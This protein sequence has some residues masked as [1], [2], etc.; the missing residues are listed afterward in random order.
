MHDISSYRRMP[1]LK[2]YADNIVKWIQ[3]PPR[4]QF[5]DWRWG[6]RSR[7]RRNKDLGKMQEYGEPSLKKSSLQSKPGQNVFEGRNCLGL[8]FGWT[9]VESLDI[10]YIEPSLEKRTKIERK[11][12]QA[13]MMCLLVFV[14]GRYI[15]KVDSVV[16]R[17]EEISEDFY[18]SKPSMYFFESKYGQIT[19]GSNTVIPM[20]K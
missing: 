19:Y 5:Q 6:A 13:P 15:K 2:S 16:E 8:V 7:I 1:M 10:P 20:V 17:S 18:L 3:P 14:G 12:F 11:T 4:N 9:S